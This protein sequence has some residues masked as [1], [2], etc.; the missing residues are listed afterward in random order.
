MNQVICYLIICLLLLIIYYDQIQIKCMHTVRHTVK[1]FPIWPFFKFY[2]KSKPTQLQLYNLVNIDNL[3]ILESYDIIPNNLIQTYYNK[4]KIPQYIFDNIQLYANN[5]KYILLDD[6]DA[7]LF[8]TKYFNIK[9]VQRFNDL[10]LG[11]HK[12]DLL[13]YCYLYV[14]GGIYLDIKTI[15]IK[16][17]DDIFTNKTYFYTCLIDFN[18]VIYNGLV[19]S[20]P[21]NPLMLSLILYIINIPLY[22]VNEP[23]KFVGYLSFCLDFYKKI[24]KDLNT[25]DKLIDGLSHGNTQ[26]YYLFKEV[27]MFTLDSTCTKFD[28]YGACNYIYDK[29]EKIFFGRDPNFP[30]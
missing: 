11:A 23:T 26:S 4:K 22:I 1:K 15:L 7:I 17:L 25:K 13:R 14:Y 20:K 27:S 5:Y 24:Q 12:A 8:L 28:R 6:N 21:R 29:N 18:T 3:P 16:H 10:K 2:D 30:W 9:I 19:A